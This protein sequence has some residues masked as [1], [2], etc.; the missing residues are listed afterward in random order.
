MHGLTCVVGGAGVILAAQ[1]PALPHCAAALLMGAVGRQQATRSLLC[2]VVVTLSQLARVGSRDRGQI[3]RGG[4]C[5]HT[6]SP[7]GVKLISCSVTFTHEGSFN[8]LTSGRTTH[9]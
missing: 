7:V 8:V 4:M 5:V 1:P 3:G 6:L 2:Q 9:T